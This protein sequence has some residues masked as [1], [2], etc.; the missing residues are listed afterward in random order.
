MI[1]IALIV[2]TMA[3]CASQ[4]GGSAG[5]PIRETSHSEAI[6]KIHTELAASYFER[7]QYGIALQEIE[8]ALQAESSYASAFNVRG[9]IRMA[10]RED[11]QA[12]QDFRRSLQLDDKDSS[13]HNNYGWFLCQRGRENEAIEQFLEAL[14]NPLYATPEIAYVNAGM[15]SKKIDKLKDAEEYFLRALARQP[16]M[17]DALFGLAD[18]S[19]A[20]RDYAGARSYFLR[21]LQRA[22]EL[23]AEHLW[24]AVR[25]ERKIGDRN[26][27]DSYALQLR[28]RYPD[29]RETQF[30]I[31]GE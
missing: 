29:A 28:K 9:L 11:K 23:T 21:F 22:P 27:A 19:F 2:L 15:C 1:W 5:T 25:I 6:A 26:S 3:G 10:L 8:I 30:L 18:V 20:K 16:N 31:Q 24:L 12:E 14:K 13:A 17:P 7:A 4:G